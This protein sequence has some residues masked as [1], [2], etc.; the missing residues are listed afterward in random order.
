[1]KSGTFED[2][3]DQDLLDTV[4]PVLNY[5]SGEI[6]RQSFKIDT[7]NKEL[8]KVATMRQVNGLNTANKNVRTY[9]GFEY[10]DVQVN[11]WN[12]KVHLDGATNGKQFKP[13]NDDS[14][15][16]LYDNS[17]VRPMHYDFSE[18]VG[19][20]ADHRLQYKKFKADANFGSN[21]QFKQTFSNTMNIGP[22][23]NAPLAMSYYGCAQCNP[24]MVS[25]S[26]FVDQ[27]KF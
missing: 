4:R 11:P 3:V 17:F 22:A 6:N 8:D 1:M 24:D 9:N 27:K 18:E 25:A 15:I 5:Q 19:T 14:P 10:I 20:E 26:S 7:G 23:H 21:T 13:H 12:G 16:S 2:G